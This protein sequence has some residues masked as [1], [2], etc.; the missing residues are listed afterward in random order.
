MWVITSITPS[1]TIRRL[2]PLHFQKAFMAS[3]SSTAA[4]EI[5][6][7]DLSSF[8]YERTPSA[9]DALAQAAAAKALDHACSQ[10]GFF[11]LAL[12]G[13]AEAAARLLQRCH[14]FHELPDAVKMTVSNQLSPM[15]R[16]YNVTWQPGNGGSCAARATIDPP[17]PKEVMMFGS[18]EPREAAVGADDEPTEAQGIIHNGRSPMH[19]PNLWPDPSALPEGWREGL[20]ED[21]ASMLAAARI[22][23]KALAKALGEPPNVFDEAMRQPASVLILL[24]YDASKLLPGSNTGCGAH[25]D[26]GFL[27]STSG[28][29]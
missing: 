2:R 10:V 13:L 11:Y 12:P 21:W 18:E 9:E 17:D 27:V 14:E 19:G 25:T 5:P 6:A 29:T 23:A 7:V 4:A 15:Y 24:R 26:C 3:L 20:E 28:S 8:C 16:G 22:L 1:I